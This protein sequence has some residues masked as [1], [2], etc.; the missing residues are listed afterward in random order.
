MDLILAAH[1]A[2]LTTDVVRLFLTIVVVGVLLW[3]V[4]A[5]VPMEAT[6]KNLLTG[7][8]VIVLVLYILRYFDLI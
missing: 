4:Q 8:V 1:T 2:M 5:Y 6:I 3:L 7:V